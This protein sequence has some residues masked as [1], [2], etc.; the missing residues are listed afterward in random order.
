ME[1]WIIDKYNKGQKIYYAAKKSYLKNAIVLLDYEKIGE[2]KEKICFYDFLFN[3]KWGFARAFWGNDLITIIDGQEI[4]QDRE[5]LSIDAGKMFCQERWQYHLQ[6][7][8]IADDPIKYLE[9]F[10]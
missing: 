10:K 7:M 2:L 4:K 9:R 1:Q 6:Q 5:L 3:P 8:V